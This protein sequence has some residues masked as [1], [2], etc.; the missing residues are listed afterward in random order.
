M[1]RLLVIRPEPGASATLAKARELGLDAIAI[2]LFAVQPVPWEKIDPKEFSGIVATSANAFR[3]GGE[4]L[5]LLKTLPVHAV[6]GSTAEAARQAGFEV[7]T[8]GE[9][10]RL[11]LGDRLPGGRLLHLSGTEP[12][13][14]YASR[15]IDPPPAIN[16]S[17]A[18]VVVHSPRASKRLS[19]LVKDRATTAIAAISPK[20]ADACGAGWERIEI[21]SVPREPALLALAAKLCQN[22]GG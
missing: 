1:R 20:A 18:V 16:A 9:G 12:V 19:E 14:V 13:A 4:Q 2:P 11:E 8:V 22:D 6:G 7:A 15:A 17:G 5:E 21:A 3:H 10:G